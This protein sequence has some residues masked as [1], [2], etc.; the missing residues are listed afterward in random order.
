M[1]HELRHIRSCWARVHERTCRSLQNIETWPATKLLLPVILFVLTSKPG[2]LRSH[3]YSLRR[4]DNTVSLYSRSP[5]QLSYL[6]NKL[7][8]VAVHA[9]AKHVCSVGRN[10]RDSDNYYFGHFPT[11]CFKTMPML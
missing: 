9:H 10:R 1:L 6:F 3:V 8:Q 11:S 4:H 7:T 2:M 5:I